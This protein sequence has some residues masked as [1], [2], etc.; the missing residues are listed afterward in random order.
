MFMQTPPYGF[1][2]MNRIKALPK[3]KSKELSFI[4]QA[5]IFRQ[6]TGRREVYSC[7]GLPSHGMPA[8]SGQPVPCH[9]FS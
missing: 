8:G 6:T 4:A 5:I 1:F 3:E 2:L 9:L 7:V